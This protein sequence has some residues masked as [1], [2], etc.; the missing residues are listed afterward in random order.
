MTNPKREKDYVLIIGSSN[1]DLNIYS[2]RLPKPGETVTGGTF[3]QSLGG[4]GANQAVAASRS[5]SDV[6]FIAKIG[7]DDFGSQMSLKLNKEGIN[8]NYMIRDPQEHSGVAFIMIDEN[9]ENM[10][11]VAP[12]ANATLS[13]EEIK[14]NADII[15]NAATLVVQMEIPLE[16][17]IEIFQI[18]AEGEVNKILNP[19]PL[20]P[21]PPELLEKIDI[22]VPNEGELFRLYSLLGFN[23]FQDKPLLSKREKIIHASKDISNL[24]I[25]YIITTLGSKGSLIIEGASDSV[26]EIPAFRV[27]AVDTV[28]AGDCFNGVLASYLTKKNS[29]IDAVKAATSG[30]SIAVTRKGAQDSMPYEEEIQSRITEYN[31][32]I[33][34]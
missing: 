22:I 26:T 24:G 30:A 32:I 14:K 5:G 17:I 18:A 25:N 19:A 12:G 33:N 11:S 27:D 15:R 23:K 2:K 6:V 7:Q 8:T 1:M 29:L 31:K 13:V 34:I 21:I 20:K 9:G 4:K 10:I 3:R 28:G 16:T